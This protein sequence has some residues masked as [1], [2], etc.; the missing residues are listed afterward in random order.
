MN[1]CMLP[2]D[3]LKGFDANFIIGYPRSG[4]TLLAGLI[5]SHDE[6]IVTPE[7]QYFSEIL[8]SR[9]AKSRVHKS[10]KTFLKRMNVRA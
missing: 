4:T 5:N 2:E 7:T 3:I 10:I 6:I 8:R 1:S 9:Q